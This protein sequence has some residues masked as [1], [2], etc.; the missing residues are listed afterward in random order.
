VSCGQKVDD[1]YREVK[2]FERRKNYE[3]M[4][5][6]IMMICMLAATTT[7]G[8]IIPPEDAAPVVPVETVV[9]KT[10][11][12][13]IEA[14]KF[15]SGI[16]NV[17]SENGAS[18][19]E[20]T[21]VEVIPI[22]DSEDKAICVTNIVEDEV[23]KDI[24]ISYVEDENN[25]M[26]VDNSV[27]NVLAQ[28]PDYDMEASFP[29]LSWNGD[30]IVHA[31]ATA[32]LYSDGF[33]TYYKPYK[34]SFYYENLAGVSVSRIQVQ[35][36]ADGFLYSYPG[37]EDLDLDEYEHVV[38]VN[39]TNPVAGTTYSNTNYFASNR[40][41]WTTS[42]S[43]MVGHFLTFYNYVNGELDTYTVTL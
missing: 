33:W 7:V 8:A 12:F 29:P 39:K 3:K 4:I 23:E 22:N 15:P 14:S 37:F 13:Y 17:L 40:V 34:C 27:A 32:A 38:T 16:L 28:G 43:P 1:M 36:I 18:I 26:V 10:A 20:D 41:L 11:E 19:E 30:Y 24:F 42:G 6:I 25:N 9:S 31:T 2:N 5:S 35:Y 21:I